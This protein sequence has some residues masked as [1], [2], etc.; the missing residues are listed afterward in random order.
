MK[1]L[2]EV[3]KKYTIVDEQLSW[4]RRDITLLPSIFQL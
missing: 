2:L 3:N 4:S 1:C